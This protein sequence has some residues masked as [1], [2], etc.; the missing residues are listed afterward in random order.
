MLIGGSNN[1]LLR[2]GDRPPPET[3]QSP[4][5]LITYIDRKEFDHLDPLTAPIRQKLVTISGQLEVIADQKARTEDQ[6]DNLARWVLQQERLTFRDFMADCRGVQDAADDIARDGFTAADPDAVTLACLDGWKA[7]QAGQ[8]QN[9]WQTIAQQ[10]PPGIV[11]L[12]LLATLAALYRYNMR[13]SSFHH[14]RADAL[15]LYADGLV[16][17]GDVDGLTKLALALASDTVPFGKVNVGFGAGNIS[18]E[19]Q[20]GK[21]S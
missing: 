7:Q 19:R 13:L 17:K 10:V 6:R 14:A 16:A 8:T 3:A 2:Y 12:F 20:P 5:D 15:E 21:D 1:T 9:W 4:T 18:L 11:L